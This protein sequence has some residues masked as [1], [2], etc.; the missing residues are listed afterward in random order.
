MKQA[1]KINQYGVY[2]FGLEEMHNKSKKVDLNDIIRLNL[3]I[4]E[5][6]SSER[7]YTFQQLSDLH[8]KLT[9]VVG[10]EKD[11][12]MVIQS[13]EEVIIFQL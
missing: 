5:D 3:P 10:R 8:D 6:N 7:S 11:Q 13:F 1:V 9:L 4:N 12:Q 2:D